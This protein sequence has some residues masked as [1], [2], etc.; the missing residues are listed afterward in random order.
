MLDWM[1]HLHC[2][3]LSAAK[4]SQKTH[5]PF[6]HPREKDQWQHHLPWGT[7]LRH[8]HNSPVFKEINVLVTAQATLILG[9]DRLNSYSINN[10]NA[11]VEFRRTLTSGHMV[12]TA[13]I[14][15][16]SASI[17]DPADGAQT[18]ISHNQ[19]TMRPQPNTQT[20][21]QNLNWLKQCLGLS[22]PN[23]PNRDE[24]EAMANLFIRNADII[25]TEYGNKGIFIRAVRIP[26]NSQSRVPKQH[27]VPLALEVD[28]DVEIKHIAT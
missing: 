22:L 9:H 23:H 18:T 6:R 27:P 19:P 25:S 20:L 24:L 28:I 1:L 3:N 17:Y 26:T 8:Y 4:R 7:R 14:I 2:A 11:T 21:D 10:R 15:P 13:P 12:H 16:A 5:D